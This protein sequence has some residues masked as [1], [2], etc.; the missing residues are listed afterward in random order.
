MGGKM[1]PFFSIITPTLERSSLVQCCES[2]NVQM[3]EKWEHIVVADVDQEHYSIWDQW[4]IRD[5]RR[6][7]LRSPRVTHQWGNFQR[8]LA[9]EWATGE[10]LLYLDD[11]NVMAHPTALQEI[12]EAL[13]S[14]GLPD[15]AL[16]P[17]HRHG[18]KFLLLPPGLCMTD[19]ANIVVKREIGRWPNIEAREADGHMVE[20]LKANFAY[21]AFPNL[22]PI[23]VMERSSNGV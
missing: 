17:I 3:F 9:W 7:C 13:V 4:E 6:L 14:D 20:Q 11:D 2:V 12:H 19:T 5:Q 15:W 10:Y 23:V 16:F 21:S 18:S 22:T 8:H 1:K